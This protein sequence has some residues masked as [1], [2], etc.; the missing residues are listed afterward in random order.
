MRTEF[1]QNVIKRV[2]EFACFNLTVSDVFVST[3]WYVKHLGCRVVREPQRF[4]D[5]SANSQIKIGV[6]T[7]FLHESSDRVK[8]HYTH[9]N[10][11]MGS[12]FELRTEN[13][14][15]FYEQLLKEGVHVFERFDNL[16]CAKYFKV[17]DPDGN[18]LSIME[19]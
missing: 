11:S 3:D 10:G 1:E 15:E 14:D 4:M 17:A 19:F 7:V 2:I 9:S 6:Q 8:I 5:G 13:I 18:V 12:I 16:P